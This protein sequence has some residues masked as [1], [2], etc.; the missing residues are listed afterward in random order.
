MASAD[1]GTV[2]N[3]WWKRQARATVS[4]ASSSVA[5]R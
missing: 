3:S 1:P 4:V 5:P 2:T